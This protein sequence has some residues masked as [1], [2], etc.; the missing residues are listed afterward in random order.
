[1]KLRNNKEVPFIQFYPKRRYIRRQIP[2]NVENDE[3]PENEEI[4]P[5]NS[6]IP[7]RGFPSPPRKRKRDD[8]E[9][10]D[11]RPPSKKVRRS[12]IFSKCMVQ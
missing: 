1:M 5:V 9:D 2:E 7:T 8:D 10:E 12:L 3:M 4:T 11:H 6:P